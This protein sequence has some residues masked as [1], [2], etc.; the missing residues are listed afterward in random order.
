MPL[1]EALLL[2]Q[3]YF[4]VVYDRQSGAVVDFHDNKSES[5]HKLYLQHTPCF[6]AA[7]MDS[8]WTRYITPCPASLHLHANVDAPV[9][10]H[11][12]SSHNQVRMGSCTCFAELQHAVGEGCTS[13]LTLCLCDA[14]DP[15]CA[16][17]PASHG[18]GF[19]PITLP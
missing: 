19:E 11:S 17:K 2:M 10:G 5:L 4:L 13:T 1:C 8:L 3:A 12:Q 6:H 9:Q 7:C 15:A 14:D 16:R 18:T